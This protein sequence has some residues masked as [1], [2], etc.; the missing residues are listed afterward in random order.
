MRISDWSSD[1]CSSDL[2]HLKSVEKVDADT[3]RFTTQGPDVS[4]EHLLAGYTAFIV[5]DEALSAF[6]EA[7]VDYKVWMD[8]A[9]NA[10]KWKPVGTGPY[11]VATYQTDA[12]VKRAA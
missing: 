5:C 9:A 2:A 7:G 11:K 8:K 1:V 6:R 10:M 12:H 3:V 4:L